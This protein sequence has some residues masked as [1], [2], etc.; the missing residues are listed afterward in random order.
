MTGLG[1]NQVR[2]AILVALAEAGGTLDTAQLM[3]RLDLA[4]VTALRNLAAL[5][6][7]GLVVASDAAA[8]RRGRR[9]SWTIQPDQVRLAA[10]ELIRKTTPTDSAI[11]NS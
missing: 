6:S 9:V 4:V 2:L 11:P 1:V 7:D 5:E 8:Q 10:E 3:S